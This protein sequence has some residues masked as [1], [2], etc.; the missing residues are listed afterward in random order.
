MRERVRQLGGTLEIDSQGDGKGT[1]VIAS[2][3][4]PACSTSA[5][6]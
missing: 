2:L 4:I 6:A 1:T 3:P 5:I